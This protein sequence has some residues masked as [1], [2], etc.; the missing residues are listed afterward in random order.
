MNINVKLN[1][2]KQEGKGL[3]SDLTADETSTTATLRSRQI[4]AILETL[5]GGLWLR[6]TL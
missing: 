2:N 3:L 4:G 6:N 5:G 1:I